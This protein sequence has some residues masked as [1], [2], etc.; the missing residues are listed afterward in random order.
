MGNKSK[1]FNMKP[2]DAGFHAAPNGNS[3]KERRAAH[4]AKKIRKSRTREYLLNPKIPS[5]Y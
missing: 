1:Q 5:R 4:R 3:R 2:G